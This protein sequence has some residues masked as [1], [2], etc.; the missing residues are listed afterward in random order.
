VPGDRPALNFHHSSVCREVNSAKP[1]GTTSAT[2]YLAGRAHARSVARRAV[3]GAAR[4]K[5]GT[6]VKTPPWRTVLNGLRC[7]WSPEQIAG[8]LPRMNKTATLLTPALP[9]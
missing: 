7:R 8:K 3:A 1:C 9:Q 4:R 6:D 2:S 5:L